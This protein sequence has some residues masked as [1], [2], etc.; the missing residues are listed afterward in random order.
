MLNLLKILIGIYL[1]VGI[2]YFIKEFLSKPLTAII[3]SPILLL[4]GPLW[5]LDEKYEK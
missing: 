4:F 3:F 2:I 1:I 5:W